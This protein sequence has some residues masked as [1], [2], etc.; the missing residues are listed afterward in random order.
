M[1]RFSIQLLVLIVFANSADE[2]RVVSEEIA[3]KAYWN[4]S[5]FGGSFAE[6][7]RADPR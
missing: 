4:S 7:R 5:Y 2:A 1:G 6:L 3:K